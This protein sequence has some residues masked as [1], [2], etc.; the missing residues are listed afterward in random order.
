MNKQSHLTSA[1]HQAAVNT[2]GLVFAAGLVAYPDASQANS[3]VLA[4]LQGEWRYGRISSVQYYNPHTGQSAQPNGSSDQF[5]LATNGTYER[6]RLL[7]INTYGCA[8]NLFIWEKGKVKVEGQ[9]F[10]FQ[11]AQSLSKGQICS[12]GRTYEKRN[13][14]Q[15]ETYGWLLETNDS[16]QQVLVLET[17]DGKGRAHYGRS[18]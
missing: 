3:T 15:P 7:Q 10:T 12:S 8:S 13:G 14:A 1:A 16:G 2:L 4:Q 5:K 18:Q 6:N 17:A 11:P 9:R